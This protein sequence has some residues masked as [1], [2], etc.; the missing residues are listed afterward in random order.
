MWN[1]VQRDTLPFYLNKVMINFAWKKSFVE[2]IGRHFLDSMSS[3][4]EGYYW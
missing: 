4:T 2:K 1:S 3:Q